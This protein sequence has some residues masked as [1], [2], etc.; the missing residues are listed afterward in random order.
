MY[1]INN[2]FEADQQVWIERNITVLFNKYNVK[3][4]VFVAIF[5]CVIVYD[6]ILIYNYNCSVLHLK[7]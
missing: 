7:I 2:S 6:T 4:F 1:V 5:L 3:R